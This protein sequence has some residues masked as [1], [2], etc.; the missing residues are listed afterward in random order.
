[1]LAGLGGALLAGGLVPLEAG[2]IAAFVHGLAG[3]V[4]AERSGAPSAQD[5]LAALPEALRRLRDVPVGVR[6][7]AP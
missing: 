4:A 2:S 3:Q 5:L 7:T 1:V 6:P